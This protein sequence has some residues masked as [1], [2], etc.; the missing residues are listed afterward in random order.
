M[1]EGLDD[2]TKWLRGNNSKTDEEEEEEE[3]EAE[4][5]FFHQKIGAGSS[6]QRSRHELVKFNPEPK[7]TT[8]PAQRKRETERKSSSLC[9]SCVSGS[10]DETWTYREAREGTGN[11]DSIQSM[12]HVICDLFTKL[13]FLKSHLSL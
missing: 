1:N 2:Q 4:R 7:G 3:E 12:D 5:V 6:G 8:S 13:E 11:Y 10:E 9:V